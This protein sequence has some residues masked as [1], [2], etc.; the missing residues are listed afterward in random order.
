[1]VVNPAFPFGERDIGPTPTGGFIVETLAG[2]TFAYTEGGFNC[3]DVEDVAEGHILAE[4]KGRVGERYILGGHNVTYQEFFTL[5]ADVGGVKPPTRKIPPAAARVVGWLWEKWADRVSGKA[6]PVTYKTATWAARNVFYECGKARRELGLPV[7]PL[8][9][10][11][12][13]SVRWFRANG[14][15]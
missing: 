15:A 2:R 12:E 3:V 8:R 10:S 11:I 6:P 1:V 7:T 5:V 9:E 13:R 14:Y 4:E